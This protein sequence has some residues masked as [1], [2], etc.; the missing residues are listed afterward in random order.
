MEQPAFPVIGSERCDNLRWKGMFISLEQNP[1]AGHDHIYWCLKTQIGIGPDG[2][3]VDKYE[4]NPGRDCYH[5][6]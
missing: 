5:P 1:A 6:L 3:L 2:R 4:C